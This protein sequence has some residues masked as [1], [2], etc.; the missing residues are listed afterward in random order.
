MTAV[1]GRA[2]APIASSTNQLWPAFSPIG[3]A[4]VLDPILAAQA[5]TRFRSLLARRLF[6]RFAPPLA[7][8]PLEHGYPPVPASPF[9]FWR[10]SPLLSHYG[11]KVINKVAAKLGAARKP[12]APTSR[13]DDT[14]LMRDTGIAEWRQSPLILQSGLFNEQALRNLF[15]KNSLT[16]GPRVEQWRRLMTLEALMRNIQTGGAKQS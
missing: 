3:F 11:G 4:Q 10:F 5:D 14:A 7:R 9:N 1:V 8:I 13:P 15:D 2:I 6:Q 12:A 16:N